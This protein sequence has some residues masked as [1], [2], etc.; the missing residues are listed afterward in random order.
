MTEFPDDDARA[1]NLIICG[2]AETAMSEKIRF[3]ISHFSPGSDH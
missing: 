2:A 3:R 1:L